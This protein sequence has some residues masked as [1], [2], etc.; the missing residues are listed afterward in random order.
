M[1]KLIYLVKTEMLLKK[2]GYF[3]IVD[4]TKRKSIIMI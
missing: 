1:T 4:T 2:I 3:A